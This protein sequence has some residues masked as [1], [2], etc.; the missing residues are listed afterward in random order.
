[1]PKKESLN[2]VSETQLEQANDL[3]LR[4]SEVMDNATDLIQSCDTDGCLL[5]ANKCWL[6]T[7]GYTE[8]EIYGM[9]VLDVI[10]PLSKEHCIELIQKIDKLR[11]VKDEEVSL[12]TKNGEQLF[13]TANI[14]CQ[15]DSDGT[16][17][18]TQAIFRDIS[19]TCYA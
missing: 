11:S 8:D 5:F 2:R 7:L 15:Y 19:A 18:G 12:I 10:H 13:T 17:K 16:P 4:M 9:S 3:G 6:E 1:M 14:N